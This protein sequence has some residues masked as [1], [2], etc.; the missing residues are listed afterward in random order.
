MGFLTFG[1]VSEQV[2]TRLEAGAE[3]QSEQVL[4]SPSGRALIDL[5]SKVSRLFSCKWQVVEG[6][7]IR[8]EHGMY[9]DLTIGKALTALGFS[10][11]F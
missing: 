5:L 10:L 9:R 8:T 6:K 2:K 7:E 4:P 11:S 1:V 3:K